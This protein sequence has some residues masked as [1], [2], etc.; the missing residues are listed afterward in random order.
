MTLIFALSTISVSIIF[1]NVILV[2][3]SRSEMIESF[4]H[5]FILNWSNSLKVSKGCLKLMKRFINSL[6]FLSYCCIDYS[7]LDDTIE[8]CYPNLRGFI[9]M[10]F[11]LYSFIRI[12]YI[13]SFRWP[14]HFI[15][16]FFV[17]FVSYSIYSSIINAKLN[18]FFMIIPSKSIPVR[19]STNAS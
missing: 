18:I 16:I 7:F 19:P 5:I 1:L 6:S 11:Y 4:I 2:F 10:W 12:F 14:I 13:T 9:W 17:R 8:G 15:R 3:S